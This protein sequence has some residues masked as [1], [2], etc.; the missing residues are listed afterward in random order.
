MIKNRFADV[1]F[2]PTP[3]PA[4]VSMG[5]RRWRVFRHRPRQGLAVLLLALLA[6]VVATDG[7]ADPGRTAYRLH[8]IDFS[9]F[10]GTQDPNSGARVDETQIRARLGL[11]MDGGRRQADWIRT[12]AVSGGL[13]QVPRIAR[14]LGFKTAAGAW[15]G[16]D[17]AANE[18]EIRGLIRLIDAGVVDLAIVGSETLLRQDLDPAA[19]VAAIR[20]VRAATDDRVPV[21]TADSYRKLLQHPEVITAGSVVMPNYYPFWEAVHIDDAIAF[22]HTWHLRL[23]A[24]AGG[25]PVIVSETGWPSGGAAIGPA[26]PSPENAARYFLHFVSWA[27]A[28]DVPYYYFQAFDEPWKAAREGSFAAHWGV[29]DE[30]GA[31]KPGMQ[32][33]FDGATLPD[34]WT[35]TLR[36]GP[37]A[38]EIRLTEV[39]PIGGH[40][41]LLG[42]VRHVN[43]GE[44]NVA[45]YIRVGGN[46]WTKPEIDN[47]AIF[48][49]RNGQWR[50]DIT[51]GEGDER[52]DTIAAFLIP[53]DFAP[54]IVLGA[55]ELPEA[56]AAGAVAQ[57]SAAR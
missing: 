18:V 14:E 21:A 41:D 54:P 20:R 49:P 2:Q 46:W 34:D 37:G 17:P 55:S 22:L 40:A 50:A 6:A 43:P 35:P 56:L 15:L 5:Q 45:V 36:Q 32:A 27:R 12:Y 57:A 24:A 48:I 3:A 11:L 28:E 47:P 7:A 4:G 30:N 31:L 39:P 1:R 25:K 42:E 9:P 26:E 13:D 29:W 19:L 10:T 44:Y 53:I 51:T 52:A 38:P 16:R 33:V 23:A 8:G